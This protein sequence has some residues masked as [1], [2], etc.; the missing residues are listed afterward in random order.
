[1]N[2]IYKDLLWLKQ[3]SID[4]SKLLND[5]KNGRDLLNLAKFSLDENQLRRLYKKTSTLQ[6]ESINI[7]NLKNLKIGIISNSTTNLAVP[8]LVGT[9]LRF[10]IL[11]QVVETEFN[12]N[13]AGSFFFRFNL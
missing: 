5:A 9:A 3:P 12:Q 11:L 4:F 2:D 10:G 7:A 13:C 1:M 8:A 6:H